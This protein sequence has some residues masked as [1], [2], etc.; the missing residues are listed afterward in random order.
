MEELTGKQRVMRSEVI[1]SL[2]QKFTEEMISKRVTLG[3]LKQI[4]SFL[5]VMNADTVLQRDEKNMKKYIE[6][7]HE[8]MLDLCRLHFDTLKLYSHEENNTGIES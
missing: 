8:S 3:E 4:V 7:V 1:W 2:I 5:V 6:K